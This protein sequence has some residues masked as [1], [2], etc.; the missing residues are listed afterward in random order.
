[1]THAGQTTSRRIGLL[2]PFGQPV[3]GVSPYADQL[4]AALDTLPGLDIRKLDLLEPYPAFAHPGGKAAGPRRDGIRWARPGSYRLAC[5]SGLDLLHI[6]YWTRISLP[7]FVSAARRAKGYGIP[8]VVTL[9]NTRP[10]EAIPGFR[11]LENRLLRLADRVIIHHEKLR[12][13]LME[14]GVTASV[15]VIP[16]GITSTESQTQAVSASNTDGAYVLAFGNIRPYKGFDVLLDAW[17]EART[18]VPRHS[19]VLAG[20]LWTGS[21]NAFASA[22]GRVLG[23]TDYSRRLAARLATTKPSERI[24]FLN[25]FLPDEE[26]DE[27]I[28]GASVAVFPYRQFAAQS[29]AACRAAGLGTVILVSDIGAL[30]DLVADADAQVAPPGDAKALARKLVAI[31]GSQNGTRELRKAQ[32]NHIRH[33]AWRDVAMSH[34]AMYEETLRTRC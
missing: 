13:D 15:T 25:G 29:G 33:F 11:S 1:M 19:L 8:I 30:P 23:L 26:L 5:P 4:A 12:T 10:H 6:Q 32:M 3:R 28:R 17:E 21:G 31:L 27:L 14:R 7:I 24:R 34:A 22:A 20:R 2:A 18:A 16:H 9:H